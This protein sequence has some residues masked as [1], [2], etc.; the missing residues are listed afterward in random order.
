[1]LGQPVDP[2]QLGLDGV[3]V[4]GRQAA[5]FA[6]ELGCETSVIIG[7][8]GSSQLGS[9][10]SVIRKIRRSQGAKLCSERSE[11]RSSSRLW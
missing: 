10:L 1:M 3:R 5:E 8:L 6:E 4:E 9:W 2:V 11:Y 7:W